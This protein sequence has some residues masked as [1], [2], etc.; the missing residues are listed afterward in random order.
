MSQDFFGT[1]LPEGSGNS[2]V[3]GAPASSDEPWHSIY[4]SVVAGET[5]IFALLVLFL[6]VQGRHFVRIFNF[7][8]AYEA[9][10]A[11]RGAWTGAILIVAWYWLA[12]LILYLV[13]GLTIALVPDLSD[14]SAAMNGMLPATVGNPGLTVT[15]AFVGG[16]SMVALRAIYFVREILLYVYLL[17]MPIGFAVAFVN[18]P[19]LSRIARRLCKQFLPLAIL[20]LPAAI[21][22]RGYALLFTDGLFVDPPTSFLQFFVVISLPIIALYVTWKTFRYASPLTTKVVGTAT[23]AAVTVGAVA[24]AGSLG[25]GRAAA[26]AARWGPR[27]G[28]AQVAATRAFDGGEP[29][30]RSTGR[31]NHDAVAPATGRGTPAY[32]RRENDPARP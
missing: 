28:A 30:T 25:G 24:G 1:P 20:P 27:V 17:G 6:A 2:L 18:V 12:V 14:L 22:F 5:M 32:R 19:V 9:R 29:A 8:S 11:K 31:T 10:R 23:T 15:M 26:T 21:L 4:E 3:F 16:V 13:D 7:S